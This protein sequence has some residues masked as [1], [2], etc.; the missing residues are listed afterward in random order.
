MRTS[1][2]PEESEDSTLWV[3]GLGSLFPSLSVVPTCITRGQVEN[4]PFSLERLGRKRP[5]WRLDNLRK[6]AWIVSNMKEYFC[7]RQI[8]KPEAAVQCKSGSVQ[9]EHTTWL[10][11]SFLMSV[12]QVVKR[13]QINSKLIT[14]IAPIFKTY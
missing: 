2:C 8:Q 12:S 7:P 9:C 13:V 1:N 5:S 14:S 10:K 3:A 6:S 4:N 11:Y